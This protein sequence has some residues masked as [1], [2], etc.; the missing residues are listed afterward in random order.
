MT[1]RPTQRWPRDHDHT[2]AEIGS[3]VSDIT[4]S[5]DI[6]F[7]TLR[8]KPPLVTKVIDGDGDEMMARGRRRAERLT[9]CC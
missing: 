6:I 2:R 8:I 1:K 3:A 7:V 4:R 5:L 9:L